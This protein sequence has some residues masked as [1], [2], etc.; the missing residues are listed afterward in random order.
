MTV[1]LTRADPS[2]RSLLARLLQLY[3]YDLS[4]FTKDDV[5]EAGEYGAGKLAWSLDDESKPGYLILVDGQ[6]AGFALVS[7]TLGPSGA[8]QNIVDKFL[9][10]RKY[11]RRGVGTRAANQLFRVLPGHWGTGYVRGNE[12]AR[13]FWEKVC[14]S[15][16][17]E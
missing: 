4:E 6:T 9:V 16:Q 7:R 3:C 5:D 17:K 13:L 8:A 1:E 14:K 12:P 10:L 15:V 2:H 11:C